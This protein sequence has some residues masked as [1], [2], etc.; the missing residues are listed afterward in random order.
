MGPIIP[1]FVRDLRCR[2]A[3]LKTA[4]AVGQC[5]PIGFLWVAILDRHIKPLFQ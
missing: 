3:S 5:R 2:F 1:R 4:I